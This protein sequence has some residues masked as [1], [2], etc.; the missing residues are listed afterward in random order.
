M[1]SSHRDA[2]SQSDRSKIHSKLQELHTLSPDQKAKT[3]TILEILDSA[4]RQGIE[5]FT[6]QGET[7]KVIDLGTRLLQRRRLDESQAQCWINLQ[8][9]AKYY[10]TMQN[11]DVK[12]IFLEMVNPILKKIIDLLAAYQKAIIEILKRDYRLS[13]NLYVDEKVLNAIVLKLDLKVQYDKLP[14]HDFK[15]VFGKILFSTPEQLLGVLKTSEEG[16]HTAINLNGFFSNSLLQFKAFKNLL[17]HLWD[18]EHKQNNLK[19]FLQQGESVE[20]FKQKKEGM[21]YSPDES[22]HCLSEEMR[23]E[24]QRLYSQDPM[25]CVGFLMQKSESAVMGPYKNLGM[26]L[27]QLLLK[28]IAICSRNGTTGSD[29]EASLKE[30]VSKIRIEET[31]VGG[32]IQIIET[33]HASLSH[34][35]LPKPPTPEPIAEVQSGDLPRVPLLPQSAST[36][37]LDRS[38]SWKDVHSNMAF[39]SAATKQPSC[40]NQLTMLTDLL[41]E[42]VPNT[43]TYKYVSDQYVFV[44]E[45]NSL[46]WVPIPKAKD[47]KIID[48]IDFVLQVLQQSLN[49]GCEEFYYKHDKRSINVLE[50]GSKLLKNPNRSRLFKEP[51]ELLNKWLTVLLLGL[52]Q[53]PLEEVEHK[54]SVVEK[55]AVPCNHILRALSNHQGRLISEMKRQ[56]RLEGNFRNLTGVQL[57]EIKDRLRLNDLLIEIGDLFDFEFF[58]SKLFFSTPEDVKGFNSNSVD[59][60]HYFFQDCE[61]YLR[62]FKNCVTQFWDPVKKQQRLLLYIQNA[63]SPFVRRQRLG[64]SDF[65]SADEMSCLT[66]DRRKA[67]LKAFQEEQDYLLCVEI[68]RDKV[69][70]HI[71]LPNEGLF[72]MMLQLIEKGVYLLKDLGIEPES[73][74][75]YKKRLEELKPKKVNGIKQPPNWESSIE[76]IPIIAKRIQ[77]F[78]P[79][80]SSTPIEIKSPRLEESPRIRDMKIDRKRSSQIYRE[81]SRETSD[82]SQSD[83]SKSH[84]PSGDTLSGETPRSHSS[85]SVS[86][87]ERNSK[88]ET[89]REK[90]SHRISLKL[91]SLFRLS[92]DARSQ[93]LPSQSVLDSRDSPHALSNSPTNSWETSATP[94]PSSNSATSRVQQ[95]PSSESLIF[96]ME[97][98]TKFS[99][100]ALERTI[101]RLFQDQAVV[102]LPDLKRLE[103]INRV[104]N[105]CDEGNKPK[106]HMSGQMLVMIGEFTMGWTPSKEKSEVQKQAIRYILQTVRHFI[107]EGRYRPTPPLSSTLYK[108]RENASIKALM[109]RDIQLSNLWIGLLLDEYFQKPKHELAQLT[110]VLSLIKDDLKFIFK[111][112]GRYQKDKV[113][114]IKEAFLTPDQN[115]GKTLEGLDSAK[116]EDIINLL[117]LKYQFQ[118]I[119]DKKIFMKRLCDLLFQ[120]SSTIYGCGENSFI[121]I[122]LFFEMWPVYCDEYRKFLAKVVEEDPRQE[123]RPLEY[124]VHHAPSRTTTPSP[125]SEFAQAIS[126]ETRKTAKSD[127]EG[128]DK[129][130]ILCARHVTETAENSRSKH[131]KDFKSLFVQL[132]WKVIVFLNHESPGPELLKTLEIDPGALESGTLEWGDA[133]KL[134]HALHSR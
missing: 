9:T 41:Q 27:M 39:V 78:G 4:L 35:S 61:L 19:Q 86:S 51:S 96:Q 105:Q 67:L 90:T 62:G 113:K 69:T 88:D 64:R 73:W 7:I 45:G 38:I 121:P 32:I 80:N 126:D 23:A 17:L 29:E 54:L 124:F 102:P 50:V 14:Y 111:V 89:S 109:D 47:S 49:E 97:A 91:T 59:S 117:D 77:S 134:M 55:I 6:L 21:P 66:E 123:K 83:H 70:R 31:T 74:E 110:R 93:S 128:I 94:S 81:I 26:V 98:P 13:A 100:D 132:Y 37:T 106:R 85:A 112:L 46:V 119:L 84:S 129:H 34:V 95:V 2:V 28:G 101:E 122:E 75:L 22:S 87:D 60:L 108:L 99:I 76:F 12:I 120:E 79:K 48:A 125:F 130:Y 15:F 114:H 1:D 58:L 82:L 53:R 103:E 57:L 133:C 131:F 20:E 33:L 107:R 36:P 72:I 8:L 65:S 3:E 63:E 11:L 43:A 56:Y 10:K 40:I 116:L 92:A 71:I 118:K 25:K 44:R 5:E 52:F 16:Q 30:S 104:L 68:L 24:A 127:L 18:P 42:K 115:S